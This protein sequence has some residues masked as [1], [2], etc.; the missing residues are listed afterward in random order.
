MRGLN[1][2]NLITL[3]RIGLALVVGPLLLVE[4]FGPRLIAFVVFLAA[5]VSDL[6]D[7]HL[8]RSRKL[9]TDLGKLLDPLA[10]KLLLAATF[11]PLYL[12]SHGW[13]TRYGFPWPGGCLPLWIM[14]VIFGR[15]LFITVFRG[16]AAKRGVV[17][18]AG[19][20]G[21]YKAVCQNVFV[22]SGILWYAFHDLA[23]AKGWS[24]G[25]WAGWEKFHYGFAF[26][27]LA[28]AVVLTVYSLA[29]YMMQYRAGTAGA[30]SAS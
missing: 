24:G 21:K 20:A 10:D 28:I 2:P 8:A 18:A 12:L 6:V 23:I 25:F 9:I 5:A 15:E 16:W 4:G 17:M 13:E 19:K 11:I 29:V 27:T 7:G 22:G 1:L 30:G 26:A 14:I 3:A